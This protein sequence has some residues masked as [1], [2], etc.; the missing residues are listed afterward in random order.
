M[1]RRARK[2]EELPG[3]EPQIDDDIKQAAQAYGEALY[4]RMELQEEEKATKAQL[5]A[6]MQ[7]RA[8]PVVTVRAGGYEYTLTHAHESKIKA[9]RKRIGEEGEEELDIESDTEA[10]QGGDDDSDPPPAR[11]ASAT[12]LRV[13][14]DGDS[15]EG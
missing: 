7:A 5:L 15:E 12:P 9:K 11:A 14:A 2:Q 1:A 13:L 10:D 4:A 3:T 8:V 6:R